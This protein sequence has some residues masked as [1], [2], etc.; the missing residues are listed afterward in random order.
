MAD[1]VIRNI[2]CITGE[3]AESGKDMLRNVTLIIK[4]GYIDKILTEEESQTP[5]GQ[6]LITKECG[7]AAFILDGHGR[8]AAP[9][10]VNTHTHIAMGLFRNYADDLE[11]MD[12]LEKAI[13]PA[14]AKLTNELVE[15]GTRLGIAEMFRSGTTCFSDMYF[16]MND[17]AKVVK[18]TGIRAVYHAVWPG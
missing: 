14:E 9:G 10:L 2:D 13:W 6:E 16:F 17:T 8:V 4:D 18:E 5:F 11:L 1:I 7:N 3:S 15:V 12:W